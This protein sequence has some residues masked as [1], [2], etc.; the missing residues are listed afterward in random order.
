MLLANTV[1][2]HQRLIFNLGM[3][4]SGGSWNALLS[5]TDF[6]DQICSDDDADSFQGNL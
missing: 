3:W 2:Y 4:L 1:E 5:D 6:I